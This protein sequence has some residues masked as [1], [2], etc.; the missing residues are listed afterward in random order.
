M[1]ADM[2]QLLKALTEAEAY[3]GPSIIIGYAPCE[4]HGIKGTMQ[5]CQLEMK[6]AV[7]AGYWQMFRYN[8]ALKE[9]GKNPFILTSK[10]PNGQLL[11]FMMGETRFASLTRTFPEIAKEL[12]EDAQKFCADRYA[13]Y[14]KLA[15][16]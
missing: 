16:G 6:R 2:N 4:M 10:E 5:N 9:E 14:K 3:N 1:G 15:E 11:D 13:K 8:P 7:D 12:F